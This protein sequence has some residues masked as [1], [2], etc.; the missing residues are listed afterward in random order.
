MR[1]T[2]L[3]TELLFAIAIPEKY[4]NMMQIEKFLS[5]KA[6]TISCYRGIVISRTKYKKNKNTR[7]CLWRNFFQIY[8]EQNF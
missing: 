7:W 2:L 8:S 4:R 6:K 3:A 1:Q 5:L